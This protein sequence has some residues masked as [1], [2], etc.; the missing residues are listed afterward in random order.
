M[1]RHPKTR[2]YRFLEM[3]PGLFTW[4]TFGAAIILS[5]WH[6]VWVAFY[7]ILFD[8]YWMFKAF[9][10]GLHLLHTYKMMT[11]EQRHDWNARLHALADLPSHLATLKQQHGRTRDRW[12]REDL[13]SE[14][15]R[16]ERILPK[17][18]S[19]YFEQIYHLIILP[20]VHEPFEVIKTSLDSYAAAEY[21]SENILFVLACEERAGKAAM[22]VAKQAEAAYGEKFR[23][24]L[25]SV[26]P[27]GIEGEAKTKGANITYAARACRK[28]LDEMQIPYENVIVSAF[29]ADTVVKPSYFSQLAY[30]FLT[31]PNRTRASYQPIA[32]YHNNVWETPAINR[33]A[34][35]SNS[36]WLMI[37]SSR[38]DRLV[39]FSSHSMSYLTL[40]EVD[41]WPVDVIPE[42]S[43]IF[44]RCF[45]HYNGN[46]RTVPLLTTVSLDAVSL[47]SYA[48]SIVGQYKQYR[49][50]A[51][52][53][54]DFPYVVN[55][56][57][58]NRTIPLWKKFIYS[59]RLLEGHYF[60]A[61]AAINIAILGWLPLL[62]GGSHF[63]NQVFAFNLPQVTKWIMTVSMVFLIFSVI[64]NYLLLPNRPHYYSRWRTFG[65][66]IQWVL[67]PVVSVIVH[68]FPAIDAQTRLLFGRYMEFWVTPK[69]RHTKNLIP[70]ES[71]HGA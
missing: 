41:F 43:Q 40:V 59:F 42:D 28:I 15:E 23:K 26:H 21:R 12:E 66:L 1:L 38:A 58:K 30:R 61:T 37:E 68:A 60:W 4:G 34:A 69:V 2:L 71:Q 24:F 65:M 48:S 62:L 19:L 45:L 14:I 64:I 31:T 13:E 33:I 35:I 39:T 22:E 55:G 44:W 57:L 51:W 17:T 70:G 8:L 20:M 52:G 3:I 67:V 9:N 47:S 46:Y 54:V 7:I 29:D 56:F 50:W 27:D 49:R 5:Y 63:D 53:V 25:V 6:P 18:A 10:I 16:L 36:F 32:L 11:I